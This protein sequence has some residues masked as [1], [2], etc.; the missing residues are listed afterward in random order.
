MTMRWFLT[1]VLVVALP[2]VE[3]LLLF[4][5][6]STIGWGWTF[7]LLLAGLGLGLGLMR[8]AGVNAFR[9]VAEPLRNRQP[10]VEIDPVTGVRQTVQPNPQPTQEEIA[11]ATASVRRSGWL[12][13]AGLLFALPGF[14]SDALAAV[15][16][17]PQVRDWLARRP[18]RR[19]P[20]GPVIQ[21]E[22]VVMDSDGTVVVRS[23]GTA[24]SS[25]SQPAVR[26]EILPPAGE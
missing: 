2:V 10:L 16:A 4:W 25:P 12:F 20:A 6:G 19:R 13:V 18:P 5:V 7:A 8:V 22:T 1:R 15:L 17:L 9:A 26:G 24:T 21:G 11:T 23:W 3:V 14:L